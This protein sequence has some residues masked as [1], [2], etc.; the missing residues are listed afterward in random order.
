MKKMCLFF[1]VFIICVSFFSCNTPDNPEDDPYLPE[2]GAVEGA[3]L[4]LTVDENDFSGTVYSED[5]PDTDEG[6][7]ATLGMMLGLV[8]N[9]V[10]EYLGDLEDA[11]T[12]DDW[13]DS[14]FSLTTTPADLFEL[15]EPPEYVKILGSVDNAPFGSAQWGTLIDGDV[16][17]EADI[18]Y[19]SDD[20]PAHIQLELSLFDAEMDVSD[21]SGFDDDDE[22]NFWIEVEQGKMAASINLNL[23][24]LIS[25]G[26]VWDEDEQDYVPCP[27]RF[28]GAYS[29]SLI[30]NIAMSGSVEDQ[31]TFET[32]NGHILAQLSIEDSEL[33]L[34]DEDL[35]GDEEALGEYLENKLD[36]DTF[37]LSFAVYDDP[38]E[39]SVYNNTLTLSQFID[40]V[41]Q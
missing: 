4:S 40:I 25:W 33:I 38:G 18:S 28:Y 30:F 24:L 23:D 8:F 29:T 22:Q 19:N 16:E 7:L 32:L 15:D 14:Y 3:N 20:L 26:S 21:L 5:V 10:G 2:V 17:A 39:D 41:S 27:T 1:M 13:F 11:G 9:E 35:M 37:D 31:D 6:A 34:I 12:L 36:P